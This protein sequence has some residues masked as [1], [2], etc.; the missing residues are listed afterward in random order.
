VSGCA[1]E[2]CRVTFFECPAD[3][4][5]F[6]C[7]NLNLTTGQGWEADVAAQAQ[8]MTRTSR[9]RTAAVAVVADSLLERLN[10]TVSGRTSNTRHQLQQAAAATSVCYEDGI[11]E[12]FLA[13]HDARSLITGPRNQSNTTMCT[14]FAAMAAAEAALKSE[15]GVGPVCA[16]YSILVHTDY[17]CIRAYII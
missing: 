12:C 8:S 14:S 4:D 13:L 17:W 15:P 11:T 5:S 7:S 2:G 1:V 9:F 6:N 3:D 10:L 16:S